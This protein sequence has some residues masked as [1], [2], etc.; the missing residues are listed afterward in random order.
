MRARV[1]AR[2]RI[3]I[4]ESIAVFRCFFVR[5]RVFLAV[6]QLGSRICFWGKNM[7]MENNHRQLHFKWKSVYDD[8]PF[9]DMIMTKF[10]YDW[11]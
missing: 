2:A 10:R 11:N 5:A 1:C 6:T 4:C 9:L 8:F 3:Q 7:Y